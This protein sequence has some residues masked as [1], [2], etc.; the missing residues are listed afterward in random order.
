MFCDDRLHL[1]TVHYAWCSHSVGGLI[2]CEL[3]VCCG[4][5]EAVLTCMGAEVTSR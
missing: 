5:E 3:L 4:S 1:F 2:G